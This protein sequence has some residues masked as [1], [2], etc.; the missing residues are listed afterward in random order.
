MHIFSRNEYIYPKDIAMPLNVCILCKSWNFGEKY[1]VSYIIT[2]ID[3]ELTYNKIY[4]KVE[5]NK[6]KRKLSVFLYTSNIVW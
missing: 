4:L 6:H 5:N 2:K 1:V 3:S